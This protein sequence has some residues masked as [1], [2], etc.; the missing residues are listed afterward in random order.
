MLS[1]EDMIDVEI[2]V[3]YNNNYVLLAVE[4]IVR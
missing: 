4:Q 3:Q 1:K 2:P